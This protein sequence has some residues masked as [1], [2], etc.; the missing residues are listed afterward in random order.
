MYEPQKSHSQ[1]YMGHKWAVDGMALRWI[2]DLPCRM[3]VFV[4]AAPTG[5][6]RLLLRLRPLHYYT[7]CPIHALHTTTQR[8]FCLWPCLVAL[9]L[10]GWLVWLLNCSLPNTPSLQPLNRPYY[11]A[12]TSSLLPSTHAILPLVAAGGGI[13]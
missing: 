11:T 3:W 5:T 10:S 12:S 1:A 6:Y 13:A 7:S 4:D 2:G 8:R 9:S